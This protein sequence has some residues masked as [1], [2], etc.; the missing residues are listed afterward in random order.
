VTRLVA[1]LGIAG[2]PVG[3]TGRPKSIAAWIA[4]LLVTLVFAACGLGTAPTED[5][6]LSP[7]GA[8]PAPQPAPL[9]PERQVIAIVD[10]SG[11][12]PR[13]YLR[14]SLAALANA[15]RSLP[16]PL[17]PT[18]SSPP[19]AALSISVRVVSGA[20]YS[21]AAQLLAGKVHAVPGVAD[22]P[23]DVDADLTEAIT[24]IGE[25]RQTATKSLA[26]ARADAADLAQR[27][28]TLDPPVA[29]ESDIVG[30]V[31]AA[32]ESF[33]STDRRLVI[34][35]SDLAQNGRA[36]V[37]G[38]LRGVHVFIVHLCDDAARCQAQKATWRQRL[39]ARGARS[40]RFARIENAFPSLRSFVGG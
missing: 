37:A 5:E 26:E 30:A 32:A 28:S 15:V 24:A 19:Q 17:P 2:S 8:V 23:D 10:P 39:S 29:D 25:Q 35:G 21:P 4:T 34:A 9:P 40:L 12:V 11:S 13:P 1:K 38:S 18:G 36:N 20:A 6:T 16:K 31:S 33:T 7:V 14:E 3:R 27:I 22:L